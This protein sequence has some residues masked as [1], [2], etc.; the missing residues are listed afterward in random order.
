M[1]N[2]G[3]GAAPF[4]FPRERTEFFRKGTKRGEGGAEP[5]VFQKCAG[6]AGAGLPCKFAGG[7]V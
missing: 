1:E 3:G 4:S 7:L 5:K 6:Q 2:A